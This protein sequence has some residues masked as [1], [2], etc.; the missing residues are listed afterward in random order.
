MVKKC[1][2]EL[3]MLTYKERLWKLGL[4]SLRIDLTEGYKTTRAVDKVDG[5]SLFPYNIVIFYCN[6]VIFSILYCL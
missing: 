5:H 3:Q 4:L 1:S 6:S 2:K